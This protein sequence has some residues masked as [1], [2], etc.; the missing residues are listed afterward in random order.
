MTPK[1]SDK[2]ITFR[3]TE[4]DDRALKTLNRLLRPRFP[5]MNSTDIIRTAL[6]EAERALAAEAGRGGAV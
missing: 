6:H 2:R 5:G 1:M 3:L 4:D